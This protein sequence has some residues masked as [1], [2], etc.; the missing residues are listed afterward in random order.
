MLQML[1]RKLPG[2]PPT[3]KD[4]FGRLSEAK[5][6]QCYRWNEDPCSQRRDL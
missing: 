2:N 3:K 5:E 6:R 1:R 4:S